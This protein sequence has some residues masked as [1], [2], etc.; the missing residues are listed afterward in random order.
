MHNL[1][2]KNI[3]SFIKKFNPLWPSGTDYVSL[4]KL[5]F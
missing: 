1:C 5:R 2:R 3:K 4:A